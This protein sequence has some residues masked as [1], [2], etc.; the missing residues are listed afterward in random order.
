ML[1][2]QSIMSTRTTSASSGTDVEPVIIIGGGLAGLTAAYEIVKA[3]QKCVIVEQENEKNLGG[4]AFWS[5]GGIFLVSTRQQYWMGVKDSIELARSDWMNS[6]QFD[7]L[8]DQDIWAKKW[9]EAY[10]EFAHKDMKN[11]LTNLGLGFMP[12]VGWAE[13]G[14]GNSSGHGNSVP[15]FHVTWGTGPGVVEIFEKPVRE[16]AR[17]GLVDFRFRHQVD[18]ILKDSFGKAIGVK[19]TILRASDAERGVASTREAQGTFEIFGRAVL[20]T[21]G[22]IGGNT[23]LIK[24][25]WPTK[26]LGGKVPD[27]F[28]TGVP[29]HVDG[30][31]LKIA[32][33]SGA[34]LVNRDRMWHYTEGLTNWNPIWP[35]HGIRVIPGPSSIW[36]N[37]TG[38]RMPAPAFPGCDTLSTLK[39]ILSSG[40]DYSWFILDQTILQKEFMLSGSEQ[41]P[42][43]T[44]KSIRLFIQR[45]LGGQEP[46][47]KFK[48]HGEDFVVS[49]NLADLVFGMNKLR[50]GGAPLLELEKIQ[51][52]VK[53][54]DDQLTNPFCKD[55][56][57]MVIQNALKFRGDR[58]ARCAPLH[59]ILDPKH[60]PLIAVRMNILTRKT[61]GGIQTN[62]ESQ[63]LRDNGSAFPGLYAA[64]E[65]AGFGGGG[66]HGYNALEG[67]FLTGCI[68]S[69]RAAGRALAR[70]SAIFKEQSLL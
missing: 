26:R 12:T 21:S 10:V 38:V 68:F 31:M 70:D 33:S 18:E 6:A 29:A 28:V 54:R 25:M 53:D 66:V 9:A 60:G 52:I 22:G 48:E 40:Y 44:G 62:L 20:V 39:I 41:N 19:G 4:Q 37:A 36:L 46:V 55:A 64:G 2:G 14:G 57:I 8:D 3:R 17:N 34:R 61:L 13:R 67:T 45:L 65:V 30:R 27:T 42:D 11:Y 58:I 16:A 69:G 35:N 51:K 23:A 63:V 47:K 50:R 59:R 32:E 49:N 24:E 56:Q 5:L 1:I 7:R 15:R 43:I